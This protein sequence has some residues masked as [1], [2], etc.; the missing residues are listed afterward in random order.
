MAQDPLSTIPPF[1][2]DGYL[3]EGVHMSSEAEVM[4]RFGSSNRPRRRLALRLRRW[5]ELG[6]Q[7]GAKR[8]L[9]DG[10][11]V[12]AKEEPYDVD[13]VIFLPQDFTRQVERELAPALE[14][15]EMLLTRRPEEIF[16]A[17]D[18]SDWEEWVK[19][20]SQTREP[21]GRRKGLVEIRL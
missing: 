13:T 4:F 5:I 12:T 20:F 7:V 14:L 17:E 2:L 3:P 21:D 6:R 9:I 15:E 18:E 10:S 16:A 8:L 19:F 11:Y 1:R